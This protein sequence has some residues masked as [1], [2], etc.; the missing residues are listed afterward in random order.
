[1]IWNRGGRIGRALGAALMM[2]TSA[3]ALSDARAD[4]YPTR[5]VRIVVPYGAGGIA[6]VTMR[7]VAQ[8]L[9]DKLGQQF[10]IDNRPSAGG[11]IGV[12]SVV[13]SEPDG[14]TLS[15]IGG[16]LTIA[17]SLFKSLPYDLETDLTPISTTAFYGLVIAAKADSP[18]KSAKD[19]IAAAKAKPGKLNFGSINPGS[20]QHLS[21]ELF[22]TLAGIDVAMIPYKATP[23]L[24]TGLIRGD[25]DVVFEYQAALQGA[26]SDQQIA[27]IATTGR[28]R[29]SSLPDVPTVAESGL[30][31]YEVT[32][33]NGLAAPAATPAEVIELLNRGVNEAL[34]LPDVKAATAKFGM[35]ARGSTSDDLRER[36][37]RDVAKWAKVIETAG[38]EKK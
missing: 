33:W 15:M 37:K 26:L 21:A 6:D 27:A 18:L 38:I 2:V 32:S 20:N 14:Y 29:A 9:S 35:D 36:I 22:K 8:K 4:T 24:I 19:L 12:R 13:T 16:G 1:M 31:D 28:E 30:P 23:E 25:V 3:V 17:K 7:L 11:V 10:I 34:A 5:P